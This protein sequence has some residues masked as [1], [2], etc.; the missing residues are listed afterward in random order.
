M[1]R[2]RTSDLVPGMITAEDI[3]N[4]E[5]QLIL[6]RGSVLT[7]KSINK[8]TFYSILQIRIDDTVPES[9]V[10]TVATPPSYLDRFKDSPAFVR[11]KKNFEADADNFKNA[12]NDLIEKNEP[13]DL[14]KLMSNTMQTLE[15]SQTNPNVFEML[16]CMREYDD[17]TY[18][19]CMNVSLICNM[20][21]RWLRFDEKVT[22]DVTISGLL[23]DVGKTKIPDSI[24]KKPGKLTQ[25]EYDIV[26]RHPQEGYD[27]LKGS[28][29]SDKILNAV[30]MHHERCDGSGYPNGLADSQIDSYAKIVAIADVYDALTSARVY[31]GPLCPF[32]AIAL[33]EKE[34]FQ[35]YDVRYILT[36]LENVVN[37]YYN[38][39]VL[40]NNG[41]TGKII[42]INKSNLAAPTIQ[43]DDGFLDLSKHPE[44]YIEDII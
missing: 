16:H 3:F 42:F 18:I 21:A 29:A 36:F 20:L 2:V 6:P 13:I 25:Q 44:L 33:F 24:I 12:I 39:T 32:K 35:K 27:I 19:H 14:D 8:L 15:P 37:T 30:L 17:A 7:D 41:V 4:Y 11:F 31:R 43:T 40:L 1:K 23:H 10:P 9:T 5:R 28:I 38:N 26:K 22:R 34:G